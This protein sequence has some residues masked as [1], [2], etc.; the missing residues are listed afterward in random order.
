MLIFMETIVD[1]H[2]HLATFDP[3][4]SLEELLLVMDATGAGSGMVGITEMS[5]VENDR[6]YRI[7]KERAKNEGYHVNDLGNGFY[8]EDC[9]KVFLPTLEIP[10][11][12]GHLLAIA[13]KEGI[14]I[15]AGGYIE[16]AIKQVCDES[17]YMP[18]FVLPHMFGRDGVGEYLMKH[19]E[20]LKDIN[21]IEVWN[22]E[23]GVPIINKH[24]LPGTANKKAQEFYD[25]HSKNFNIG[26]INSS[27]GHSLSE[28]FS[29]YSVIERPFVS[30]ERALANSLRKS[31]M[32]ADGSGRKTNSYIGAIDHAAKI[33]GLI[34]GN[35]L[36]LR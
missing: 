36:G 18:A 28:T 32:N 27:D 19:P 4:C 16:D 3:T 29:S 9:G 2:T 33:A 20:L 34:I 24:L 6:G 13:A 10:T 8:L 31:I 7:M 21:G 14:R 35:K 15:P 23:A 12:Y 17:G 22:G 11:K 30:S 25:K 5:S 1:L 26:A